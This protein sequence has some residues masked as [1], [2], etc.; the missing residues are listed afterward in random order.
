M[1]LDK[2]AIRRLHK[3]CVLIVA[4][5]VLGGCATLDLNPLRIPDDLTGIQTK[6]VGDVAISV[7]ILT[8]EQ[9]RTHFGANL[10]KS[11]LQALWISVRNGSPYNLWFIRNTV[12]PDFYSADEAAMLL[13]NQIPRGE[14][15]HIRQYYRDESIRILMRS[16]M[17]TEGFVFLPRAVGGRYVDIRLA[18][19]AFQADIQRQTVVAD[20]VSTRANSYLEV[21]AGFALPLPDGDFDYERL[22]TE[23]TYGGMPL[24]DLDIYELRSALEDLPCCAT[25]AL[26]EENGDPLNIVIVG[27]ATD[28]LNSLSRSGWSFTHRITLRSIRRV[29][30]AAISDASYPVAPVSSLYAFG[31]KQDFAL[32]RARE[33]IAQRNHMRLWLAPFLHEGRQVWI[34]QVSRDIGIKLSL[35]SPSVTTHI[36]DPE[37]DLTREYLFHSL[38]AEGFVKRFGF[39]TGAFAATR[40]DP[41]Y[42]LTGDPYFSDGLRLVVILSADPIQ[43]NEVNNL[44]WEQVVPPTTE[45]Q[46]KAADKNV[47]PI[48]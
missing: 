24:P 41:A 43:Y 5:F 48:N 37:I 28:V 44:L 12:D 39:V 1:V 23:K 22:D 3:L 26:G 15:E 30:G 42:N 8:D 4:L 6:K 2:I 16:E 45:G 35:K 18:Q 29:V 25:E 13:K 17:I 34:G 11:G 20:T 33:S 21:R 36:I 46:T 19:D 32:Q 27:E 14:F 31:R 47:R 10:G 7:A 9:A 40:S 38:L